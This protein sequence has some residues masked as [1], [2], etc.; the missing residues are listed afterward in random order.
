MASNVESRRVLATT[1]YK[2]LRLIK[3]A[4]TDSAIVDN[5]LTVTPP[6]PPAAA[7]AGCTVHRWVRAVPCC[8][9]PL[10]GCRGV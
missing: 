7:P 10:A 1:N 6:A 5:T 4:N 8:A 9:L 2:V 3:Y